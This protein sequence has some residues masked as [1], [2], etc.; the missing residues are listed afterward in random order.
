MMKQ[1]EY[2]GIDHF[3]MIAALLIVA[4]H[5][6]PLGSFSE[7]ADFLLTR[8]LARIAVPF[9]FMT[10]GFFLFQ[11]PY[12]TKKLTAFL[13]KTTVIY[14]AAI[15]LYLPVNIYNGYFQ[16][17]WMLPNLL[18]D[19][20]FDGTFYHLW[21]LP[22]SMLGGAL[23][24][25]LITKFSYPKAF[26]VT[27]ILYV[28][29]L[30]GDSCYGIAEK[31]P[32]FKNFY[33]QIFMISDYTRNGLFFAPFFFVL[34]GYFAERKHRGSVKQRSAKLLIFL[35]LMTA[36]AMFLRYFSLQRHDSMYFFLPAVLSGLFDIL[37]QFR[38]KR[39]E[40]LRTLSFVVYLLHPWMII[41]VRLLAKLLHLQEILIQNSLFHFLLVCFLSIL[42]GITV[43][44]LKKDPKNRE[45]CDLRKERTWLEINL[46]HLKHNV[47]VL[48]N[49]MP[50][51]C[52]LM[53]VVKSQA[54]GHGAEK[55]SCYLNSIGV[56]AFATAT[57]EEAIQLRNLRISG[58]ILILGYSDIHRAKD[59]VKYDLTQTLI[60]RE[61]AEALD[62][63]GYPVKTH[64]KI[65]TGMHRLGFEADDIE[66]ITAAFSM[67]NLKITGIFTH[68]CVSDSLEETDIAFTKKQISGFYGVLDQLKMQG[69]RIPKI[70]IQS[71]YGLLNYP[72]LK[73]DYVRVGIALYG[74]LS[75]PKDRTKVQPDLKP[76]LSMKTQIALI[77]EIREGETVGYGRAFTAKRNSRIAILP[78][79][80]ADGYPRNLSCGKG[81][82]L[83]QGKKVPV[84]GKICMDQMA[85]D[86][87]DILEAKAGMTVTLIGTD[88]EEEIM[89]PLMAEN[90]ESISNELL[91]RMGQRVKIV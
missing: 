8:V 90:A 23:A 4:I 24:W 53:A 91:S 73:C 34:G 77:R 88:G 89:A 66:G 35:F 56:S 86:V 48:K 74:V 76:V 50:K 41:V 3:R 80:Y 49:I 30:F 2:P 42:C 6:S 46:E 82:V 16:R 27:G 7:T 19:L 64:L 68:L 67:K 40:K 28:I 17:G 31:L 81:T 21:Y 25:Y 79:G 14:G 26:L 69:I 10:S 43:L 75:S 29:G 47:Q 45:M 61:Y 1:K 18:K 83:I 87:T 44:F 15:L 70:H 60:D 55:I 72:E 12:D 13:K 52:E 39:H 57:I 38:G 65:D 58:E 71:S 54:Y 78:V 33:D 37:L 22:A 62:R 59:L 9:F 84:I 63:Q 85:V 11:F 20:I 32:F 5:T 51:D 36:E